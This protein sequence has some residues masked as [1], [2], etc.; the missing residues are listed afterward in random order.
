M[1]DSVIEEPQGFVEP[2]PRGTIR[3]TFL[4]LLFGGA[5]AVGFAFA[6]DYF[7]RQGGRGS[8]EYEEFVALGRTV[9]RRAR[10]S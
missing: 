9:L 3:K 10:R 7:A 6:A 2:A 5:L 4:A 1:S 8:K